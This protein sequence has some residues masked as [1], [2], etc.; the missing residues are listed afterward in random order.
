MVKIAVLMKR[1]AGLSVGDFQD[2]LRTRYGPLAA[3]GP[4]LRRYVQSCA[5]PQ[6]YAKGELLFDAV[7][8]M[9][10]DSLDDYDR[11]LRSPEF[12]AAREDEGVFLD[13]ARTVVMP[14]EVQVIKDGAI[15]DN[16]VK[17]IEFVNRRP[18]MALEP[19]RSY[20]R[21]VHGPLAAR[22]PAIRRYEQ[23]HLARSEY[24]KGASPPYDGLA[25]TWFA[26]T[27]E[28]R[29]GAATPEYAATRAD[30]ANFLP[31]GHLPVIITREHVV[32]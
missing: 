18:G 17:N 21:T 10:F 14:L 1:R 11:C 9:W 28:M 26:S 2:H 22:I 20:W 15:P 27:A 4:G 5:L 23:N 24:Q 12:A 31:D 32:V 19:F 25:V 13:R 8:E 30:E 3:K 29:S 6:G 16:A 7:G